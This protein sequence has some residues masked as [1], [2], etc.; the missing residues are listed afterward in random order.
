[1]FAAP[2]N[3]AVST[4]C[5]MKSGK[6]DRRDA[7]QAVVASDDQKNRDCTPAVQRRQVSRGGLRPLFLHVWLTISRAWTS[8][9]CVEADVSEAPESAWRWRK[10]RLT[11]AA[12]RE[13]TREC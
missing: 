11:R 8:F 9:C 1:M 4:R 10:G 2:A 5:G 7:M 12:G 13:A 6:S 3:H